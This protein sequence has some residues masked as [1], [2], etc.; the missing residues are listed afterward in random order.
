MVAAVMT[1]THRMEILREPIE[2][3]RECYQYLTGVTTQVQRLSDVKPLQLR[4]ASP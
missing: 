2:V 4:V 1:H 3:I